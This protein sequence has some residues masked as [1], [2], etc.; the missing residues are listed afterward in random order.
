[1]PTD[2][3]TN[4]LAFFT[5][6][7]RSVAA[8]L[9][10]I[11]DTEVSMEIKGAERHKKRASGVGKVHISFRFL[12]HH[13]GEDHHGSV[14]VPLPD[15]IGL[16]GFLM[17]HEAAEVEQDRKREDLD[18]PLKEAMLEVGNFIAGAIDAVIRT[19]YPPESSCR[20]TGCQGVRADVRPAFP[21]REGRELVI[22]RA[23]TRVAKYP[24]FEAIVQLPPPPRS[25]G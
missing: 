4:D 13:E 11:L 12:I 23:R 5:S 9:A 19:W 21:Y 6:L 24:E 1:M 25:G 2:I 3:A 14:L 8:D 18:R 7:F 17:M 15:A 20:S 16:A 10:M 22:G